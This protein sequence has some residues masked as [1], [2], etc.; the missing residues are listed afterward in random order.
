MKRLVA[1]VKVEKPIYEMFNFRKHMDSFING[2]VI[3]N[4]RTKESAV[5]LLNALNRLGVTWY[6]GGSLIE[7][8]WEN[9]E[10]EMCYHLDDGTVSF[11]GIEYCEE[12]NYTIVVFE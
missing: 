12:H 8:H 1:K 7:N 5:K 10:E 11:S 6:G 4:C 9:C 2:K 3:L